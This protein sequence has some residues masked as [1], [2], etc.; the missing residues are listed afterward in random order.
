MDG[1]SVEKHWEYKGLDC[2][3]LL[4]ESSWQNHRCGYVGVPSTHPLYQVGYSDSPEFLQKHKDALMNQTQGKRGIMT[5]FAMALQDKEEIR[6]TPEMLFN[7]HGSITFAGGGEPSRG[8]LA[9]FWYF[10][11]DCAHAGDDPDVQNLHY[12]IHEC[13]YLAEQFIATEK[14]EHKTEI[15]KGCGAPKIAYTECKNCGTI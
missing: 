2:L 10:G 3:V 8:F 6:V 13:E 5:L 9:G 7:V 11:Y 4:V 1:I 14:A 12:C 15:C